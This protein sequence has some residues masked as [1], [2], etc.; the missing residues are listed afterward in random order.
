[1]KRC[2]VHKFLPQTLN[3]VQYPLGYKCLLVLGGLFIN[4]VKINAVGFEKIPTYIIMIIQFYLVSKS[5]LHVTVKVY[6]N[7]SINLR[8]KKNA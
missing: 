4:L 8:L 6:H 2:G 5:K 7:R 3:M 1:M